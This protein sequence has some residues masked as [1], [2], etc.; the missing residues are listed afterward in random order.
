MQ[1]AMDDAASNAT[2][3]IS[4]KLILCLVSASIRV[5][6]RLLL[7]KGKI[8]TCYLESLGASDITFAVGQSVG[9]QTHSQLVVCMAHVRGDA[10]TSSRLRAAF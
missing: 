2:H 3:P 1:A 10:D 8:P 4:S 6:V 7:N 5:W 9:A